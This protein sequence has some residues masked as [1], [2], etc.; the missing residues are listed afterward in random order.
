MLTQVL[1]IANEGLMRRNADEVHFLLP[2][3]QRAETLISP[4]RE[5]ADGLDA[6]LPLEH[7]I[8][9]FAAL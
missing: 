7:F 5:M 4:A 6:G 2:L 3:Y 8:R 1:D 9:Q